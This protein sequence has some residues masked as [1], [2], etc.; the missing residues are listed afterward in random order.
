MSQG[1]LENIFELNENEKRQ[2]QNYLWISVEVL[3]RGS[4]DISAYI[5]KE[6]RRPR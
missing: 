6:E 2:Y 3:R 4:F 1:K 5:G